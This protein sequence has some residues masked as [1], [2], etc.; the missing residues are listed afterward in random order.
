MSRKRRTPQDKK[1]LS[2]QKDCRNCY[3]Q[4]DKASRKSIPFRKR[5]AT[6]SIRQAAKLALIAGSDPCAEPSKPARRKSWVKLPDRP[7]ALHLDGGFDYGRQ[8]LDERRA[9]KRKLRAR[10]KMRLQT[11]RRRQP[12][13]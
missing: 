11:T 7:L 12:G 1:V 4:S 6:R 8:G 9:D 10:A 13:I 3:G 5:K 2:Y